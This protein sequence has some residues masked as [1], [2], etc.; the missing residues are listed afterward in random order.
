[1]E[2][3]ALVYISL[4]MG[5]FL[6]VLLMAIVAASHPDELPEPRSVPTPTVRASGSELREP[7]WADGMGSHRSSSV[8]GIADP[9]HTDAGTTERDFA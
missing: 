9:T 4:T 7:S 5:V 3:L 8:V 1:M 6:G 2:H